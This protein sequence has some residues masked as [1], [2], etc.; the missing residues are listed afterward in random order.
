MFT[1]V[2]ED[3][4]LLFSIGWLKQNLIN[5]SDVFV[6]D[7]P[8]YKV[9]LDCKY[10]HFICCGNEQDAL[11]GVIDHLEEKKE[12]D[13]FIHDRDQLE[14]DFTESEIENMTVAG[15]HCHFLNCEFRIEE[16]YNVHSRVSSY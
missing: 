5:V 11:D 4:K 16:V 7:Y 12:L 8:I 2:Q 6:Y 14:D 1:N 10:E 13:M 3:E 15:N 9:T